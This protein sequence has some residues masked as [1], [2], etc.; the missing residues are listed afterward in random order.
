MKF[1][2]KKMKINQVALLL[3]VVVIIGWLM[4][5]SG[6][7]VEF[8]KGV[9]SESLLYVESSDQPNPFILCEYGQERD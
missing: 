1:S 4:M 3:A 6:V 2:F 7:R 9:K 5:R 8:N